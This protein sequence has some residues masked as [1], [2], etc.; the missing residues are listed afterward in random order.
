MVILVNFGEFKMGRKNMK[1]KN[2]ISD[3]GNQSLFVCPGSTLTS[4]KEFLPTAHP[5]IIF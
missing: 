2:K 5:G 1:N 3:E 4:P